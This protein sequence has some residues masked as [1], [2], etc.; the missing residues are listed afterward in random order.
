MSDWSIPSL[1]RLTVDE[2]HRMIE[3]GV[4]TE[5]DRIELLEG[6]LVAK[7]PESPAHAAM[8]SII[9][10]DV[11]TSRLPLGWH[12]RGRSGLTTTDSE[13]EPDLAAIRGEPRDYLKR[14]PGPADAGLII[15]V[16]DPNTLE[17]DRRLKARIY[18]NAGVPLHWIINLVDAQVEVYTDPTGPDP[19]PAYRV[20]QIYRPGDMVPFVLDGRE[21]E[22]IPAGEL[23]P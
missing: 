22:P 5:D 19:A 4:F 14:H 20:H 16:A 21:L 7:M 11:L 8:I 3:A 18:A 1:Y 23:L 6:F 12:W 17:Q 2:Y 10:G 13:P 15:E 9:A